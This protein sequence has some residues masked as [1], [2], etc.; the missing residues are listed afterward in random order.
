MRL[1]LQ[2]ALRTTEGKP[3]RGYRFSRLAFWACTIGFYVTLNELHGHDAAT[4]REIVMLF[5]V[6]AISVC[7][8]LGLFAAKDVLNY[9]TGKKYGNG[10]QQQ[11]EQTE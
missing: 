7:V 5:I 3:A 2:E 9:W 8:S 11:K 10:E 6:Y 4:V 1:A